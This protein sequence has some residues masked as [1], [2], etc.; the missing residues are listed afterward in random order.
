MKSQETSNF[1]LPESNNKS[2]SLPV[3]SPNTVDCY[4]SQNHFF[5]HQNLD[6]NFDEAS[7]VLW[8]TRTLALRLEEVLRSAKKAHLSCGQVLLP[9]DLLVRIASDV[10]GMAETEPCG[11]RGMNLL[12]HFEFNEATAT[13]G[14]GGPVSIGSLSGDP[15]LPSTFQLHL[16]LKEEQAPWYSAKLPKILRYTIRCK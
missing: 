3:G 8:V 1:S 11:L 13:A 2:S 6:L 16:S 12:L 4:S 5:L 10:V 15:S 7:S 14:S 9:P